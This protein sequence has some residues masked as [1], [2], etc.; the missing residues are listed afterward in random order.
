MDEA[1]S[2]SRAVTQPPELEVRIRSLGKNYI[3]FVLTIDM[4][5]FFENS[6]VLADEFIAHRLG[7]IPL[8]SEKAKD[9]RYTRDCNCAQNC[10]YCS[11]EISLHAKCTDEGTLSVTSRDLVSSNPDVVPVLEDNEDR[12]ILIA[13]LRKGQELHLQCVVKKGIAKEHA[14]W[15]PVSVVEFEYDPYNKLRHTDYWYEKDKASEWPLSKNAEEED[16]PDPT[17]KYDFNGTIK[18]IYIGVE[19]IDFLMYHILLPFSRLIVDFSFD[20]KLK[21][22]GSLPPETVVSIATKTIQEKLASLQIAIEEESKL[23]DGDNALATWY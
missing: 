21:T 6:S 5:E 20:L 18:N 1:Y 4:V 10:Q 11:V 8:T 14:K 17:D 9:F 7:L 16:P 2:S 15:S 12:G 23:L 19:V 3:D 13:K 22:V